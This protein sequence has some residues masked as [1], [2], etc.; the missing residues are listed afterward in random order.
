MNT[1]E[2]DQLDLLAR[3][4]ELTAR[5]RDWTGR[6]GAWEPLEDVRGLVRRVL[7]RVETV[8]VR[9]E[10]PLVVATF[11]GTGVGKSTLVNALVGREVT[12]AGRQ[13]PTTTTPVLL[14]HPDA[15][16]DV[17]DLP[18]GELTVRRVDAP[19]LRDFV[20]VDCPDPD[21]T[22]EDRPGVPAFSR[23]DPSQTESTAETRDDRLEAG[24]PAATT[25]LA[26]LRSL[27]PHCDALLVVGTQQKYLSAAVSDE[28]RQAA[29]GVRLL[30]VQTHAARDSDVRE[31]WRRHLGG[32]FAVPDLFF[33]DSERAL[34]EQRTGHAPT[35]EFARLLETLR[36][37]LSESERARVRRSNVL[38][39]VDGALS[40][41]AGE[42]D[43]AAPKLAAVSE[44]FD[45]ERRDLT[46][47]M[48]GRLRDELLES[49]GLWERRL[50]GEVTQHWGFSPF[51]WVLRFYNGLGGWIAGSTLF[52]ARNAAA[53][54][55]IG[56]VEA[57]RRFKE[58]REGRDAEDRLDRLGAFGTDDELVREARFRLS[59]AVRDARLDADLLTL[60]DEQLREQA[61]LMEGRFLGGVRTRVAEI[62]R[63]LAARNSRWFVRLLYEIA[64]AVFP[65]FVLWR[66][67]K[68][69][70]W[71]TFL[72]GYFYDVAE[73][74]P[75]LG[76]DFWLTAG[77]FLVLWA[78]LLVGLFTR[79]LSRGLN[80]RIDR[81]ARS[82]AEQR[83][84]GGLFPELERA[85]AAAESD[86]S[87]LV[88]LAADARRLRD[89]LAGGGRL[90][91]RVP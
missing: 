74:V 68:N 13:R 28:L 21:T 90:G 60:T 27:L 39:L 16:L 46:N 5:L 80:R 52:R 89:R 40:R 71:D 41:A 63:S 73:P 57:G 64:F 18:L 87:R 91:G 55:L 59:G 49:R 66:V 86:R 15:E 22:E 6:E 50:L 45:A 84:P 42:L 75:L 23:Q 35:G 32:E 34:E 12:A 36:T 56:A 19:V 37:E 33:V 54:A 38:D 25:N 44:R 24:H 9:L 53:V 3:V 43:A 70:L 69:F 77:V 29:A 51:S 79:R 17:L 14:C 20:L 30:F 88:T 72:A 81:L 48:I 10:S 61:G 7:D 31:D 2:L 85:V 8:R 67:G 47:A 26:R 83:L 62:L 4:D 1:R 65:L 58:H 11:G 76:T 78:G 82:L